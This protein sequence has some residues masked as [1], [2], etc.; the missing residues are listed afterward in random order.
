MYIFRK[1]NRLY[2]FMKLIERNFWIFL[3]QQVF[4]FNIWRITYRCTFK[5]VVSN[6]LLGMFKQK[7]MRKLWRY[8]DLKALFNQA[9]RGNH[10][11]SEQGPV[12]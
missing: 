3:L 4:L 10:S 11:R 8:S 2:T 6:V 9:F 12:Q 7:S 5:K 1:L